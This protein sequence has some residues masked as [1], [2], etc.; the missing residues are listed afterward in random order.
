MFNELKEPSQVSKQTAKKRIVDNI[1]NAL[2][3]SFLEIKI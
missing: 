3:K 1:T 2:R